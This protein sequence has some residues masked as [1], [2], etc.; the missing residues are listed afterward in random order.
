MNFRI[1]K[2]EDRGHADHGWLDARHSFSFSSWFNPE[3]MSFGLLR[4]LNDDIVA[5]GMGFGM[6]PHQDMEII[7]IPLS[8]S[9]AHSDNTGGHGIIGPGEVQVMSAGTGIMHSEV[10][11][12]Q[13]EAVSLFQLWIMPKEIGIKPRYDQRVYDYEKNKNSFVA[14]ASPLESDDALWINQD[15]RVLFG[16]FESGN[17]ISYTTIKQ[18]NG[19]YLMVVYGEAEIAKQKLGRR[20]AIG[21]WDTDSIVISTKGNEPVKLLLIDVPMG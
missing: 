9:I 12:S 21:V 10:N 19:L 8:G 16:H 15:S 1:Y 11:G 20:D 6:H 18:G 3:L 14:V 13:T 7:T 2:Q 17:E 5:P 4:V